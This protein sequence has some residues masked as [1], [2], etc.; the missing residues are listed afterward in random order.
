MK[1]KEEI[2][3]EEYLCDLEE[4][5]LRVA[6]QIR[7]HNMILKKLDPMSSDLTK[8]DA[9]IIVEEYVY[10]NKKDELD[11]YIRNNS[12]LSGLLQQNLFEYLNIKRE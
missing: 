12:V 8:E 1:I 10:Q 4:V 9:V 5:A 6:E 11:Y 2:T 3:S 7:D